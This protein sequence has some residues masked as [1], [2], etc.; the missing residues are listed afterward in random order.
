MV[1]VC[2]SPWICFLFQIHDEISIYW[3]D[4][5]S[6]VWKG[7]RT[8]LSVIRC[9]MNSAWVSVPNAYYILLLLSTFQVHEPVEVLRMN[10]MMEM[11]LNVFNVLKRWCVT[12]LVIHFQEFF[13][14]PTFKVT[15]VISVY[16]CSG[17]WGVFNTDD[18]QVYWQ[19]LQMCLCNVTSD[20]LE[21]LWWVPW[22]WPERFPPH[23]LKLF[24]N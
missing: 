5:D 16:V 18:A 15:L 24:L 20:R 11:L 1:S 12:F 13:M 22:P 3:S 4:T 10:W 9:K 6:C 7:E 14:D 23:L 21:T 17:L 8:L 2:R 19:H